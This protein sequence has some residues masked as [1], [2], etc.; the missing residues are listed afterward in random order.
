MLPHQKPLAP[1][2]QFPICFWWWLDGSQHWSHHAKGKR[3]WSLWGM[4][5]PS[6]TQAGMARDSRR[7]KSPFIHS[8]L[9][10]QHKH[11]SFSL[12]CNCFQGSLELEVCF[13]YCEK[14]IRQAK[15]GP[16]A[17]TQ[18]SQKPI[19]FRWSPPMHT[20]QDGFRQPVSILY[21][22]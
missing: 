13:A 22:L 20:S 12:M 11:L 3:S 6:R 1:V 2:H 17:C 16:Q 18:L 10:L 7:V 19:L 15:L 21:L 8:I 9:K 5:P 4:P 14:G